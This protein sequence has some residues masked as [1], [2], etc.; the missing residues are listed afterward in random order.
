MLSDIYINQHSTILDALKQMDLKNVKLLLMT[1]SARHFL[2]VISIGDIQRAII[3]NRPLDTAIEEITRP[4]VLIALPSDSQE[5]I[6]EQMLKNRAE[7]MPVVNEN[8]EIVHIYYWSDFFD[9][10]VNSKDLTEV[11][12]LIMA[13]GKGE[14]LK[15]LTDIIPKPLVPVGDKTII[16]HIINQFNKHG[17]RNFYISTNHKHELLKGYLDSI[18]LPEND[19][20]YLHEDFPLGTAGAMAALRGTKS[21]FFVSNCDIIIYQNY[22]K[23]LEFHRE[24][25][26]DA[27]IVTAIYHHKIDYGVVETDDSGEVLDI[28]EKPEKIYQINTGFYV[29]E[30]SVL[31]LISD[32]TSCDMPELLAR[33]KNGGRK[34][35]VFPIQN[36]SWFDIGQKKNYLEVLHDAFNH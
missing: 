33:L 17:C 25:E 13:G 32:N 36:S 19:I 14:R 3:K 4:H 16:E 5:Y 27:T 34:V 29:F 10:D 6:K 8:N 9:K 1:D 24:N 12:V 28:H 7:C 35:G 20:K 31:D 22:S 21:S 18:K 23:I 30:S 2:S 11:P 26:N 15:P